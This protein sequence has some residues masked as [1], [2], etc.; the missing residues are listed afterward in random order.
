MLILVTWIIR[1]EQEVHDGELSC[2]F[3]F[4]YTQMAAA[5]TV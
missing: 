3:L 2:C 5:G 1:T 4:I